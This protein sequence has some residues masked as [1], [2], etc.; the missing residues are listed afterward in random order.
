MALHRDQVSTT[1]GGQ[2]Y[3][4]ADGARLQNW[5]AELDLIFKRKQ[6]RTVLAERRHHGPLRVQKTLYPE[7]PAVCH[8]IVIHPPGGMAGG[9]RLAL[10]CAL[11]GKSHALL[12][13][14]GAGKWYKSGGAEAVQGIAHRLERAA[15][16]E[17]L[18]QE[19]ILYNAAWAEWSMQVELDTDAVFAGWDIVCFGRRACGE[20]FRHGKLHQKLTI[21]R[22][23]KMLWSEQAHFRGDDRLMLSPAGLAGAS[24]SAVMV[25][26]AGEI[27]QSLLHACRL[28]PPADDM[29]VGIS[30]LPGI[31]VARCLCN[32]ALAARDYFEALWC[33]LRPWYAHLPA[34]RPRIWNT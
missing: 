11:E 34:V 15:I 23:G 21:Y 2:P 13:T 29:R 24:V 30:A 18:P 9:D 7:D 3:D 12:T 19:T 28:Q 14:P 5:H 4:L 8:T 6:A 16:L 22:E 1:S 17:W 25:V 26:A 32:N 31:L 27:P 20:D 33:E 10:R